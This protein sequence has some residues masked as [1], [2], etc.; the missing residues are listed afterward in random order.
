MFD[1]GSIDDSKEIGDDSDLLDLFLRCCKR[2]D[3]FDLIRDGLKR[4][5]YDLFGICTL[6]FVSLLFS[7][8]VRVYSGT[9]VENMLFLIWFDS[10]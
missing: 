7:I 3:W 6:R 2:C 9:C 1:D 5:D 8:V 10:I 4:G